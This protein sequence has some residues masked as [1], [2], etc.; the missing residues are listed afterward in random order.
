M[1]LDKRL[2][3]YA[4]LCGMYARNSVTLE[5]C[6]MINRGTA[7]DYQN[8]AK[9]EL[10]LRKISNRID[11]ILAVIIHDNILRKQTMSQTY[12]RPS[13]SPINQLI[14]SPA[15]ADQ[16]A[17]AAQKEA[18][19]IITI[20]YPT[21]SQPLVVTADPTVIHTAHTAPPPH[22]IS[23]HSSRLLG[24]WETPMSSIPIIHN[25]RN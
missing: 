13:I 3:A 8:V 16:I 23:D 9:Y 19:N 21:R 17:A 7:D 4:E 6:D 24:S 1:D 18:D 12:P 15:D 11:E 10:I 2:D 22:N 20:A 5:H 25:E 14:S